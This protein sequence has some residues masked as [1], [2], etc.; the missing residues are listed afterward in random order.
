MRATMIVGIVLIVAGAIALA[1]RGFSYTREREI[2]DVGPISA[3][4]ETRETFAIPVWVSGIAI[5]AGIALVVA[6]RRRA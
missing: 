2:V 5:A 6:G 4:A 1:T 3:S